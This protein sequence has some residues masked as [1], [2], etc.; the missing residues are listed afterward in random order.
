MVISSSFGIMFVFFFLWKRLKDDYHY[1]KIFNLAFFVILAQFIGFVVASNFLPTYWFWIEL[2]FIAL[3]FVLT[4]Q[5]QKIKLFESL[6]G[7]TLGFLSWLSLYYMVEAVAK[8]SLSSFVAFW[9]CLLLVFLFFFLDTQYRRFSWYRSGR[10]GF[11]G[12]VTLILFFLIRLI[13]TFTF[14]YLVSL[15]GSFDMYL[16]GI[17]LLTFFILLYRLSINS[18]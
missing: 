2:G 9:V 15:S 4:I 10:V 11:S 16:S 3:A 6:D 5:K 13:F 14:P 1:E 17:S 12:L 18:D 8:S 7:V